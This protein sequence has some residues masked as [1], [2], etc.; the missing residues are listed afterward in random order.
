MAAF[1]GYNWTG[2]T[3]P[4]GVQ[5]GGEA[6]ELVLQEPV[7]KGLWLLQ[8]LLGKLYLGEGLGLEGLVAGPDPRHHLP[9]LLGAGAVEH[10]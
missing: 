6:V 5:G 3:L 7:D 8:G 2:N 9:R 10:S 1:L 4:G